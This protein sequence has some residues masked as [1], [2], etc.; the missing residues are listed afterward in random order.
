MVSSALEKLE[1]DVTSS[2]RRIGSACF[3]RRFCFYGVTAWL[4]KLSMQWINS[5]IVFLSAGTK[6]IYA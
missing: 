5:I 3:V 2:E 6:N 4:E 1:V